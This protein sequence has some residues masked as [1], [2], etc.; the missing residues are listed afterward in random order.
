MELYGISYVPEAFFNVS[1]DL[2]VCFSSP[3]YFPFAGQWNAWN[4]FRRCDK[5]KIETPEELKDI[6]I[7]DVKPLW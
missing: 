3:S 7:P 6:V 4:P 5:K 2:K 1:R